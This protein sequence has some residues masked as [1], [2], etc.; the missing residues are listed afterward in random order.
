MADSEAV[1]IVGFSCRVAGADTPDGFWELLRTGADAVREFPA[2]RRAAIPPESPDAA[3]PHRPRRGGYLDEVDRFDPEFFGID[4]GEAALMDP[5]QRLMLELCWEALE[6]A[7]IP[8][9]G[10]SGG[11]VGVFAG[12]IWDDYAALLRRAGVAAGSRQVTGLHRSMIANRV[13][14]ALGLRTTGPGRSR[15]PRSPTN[16]SPPCTAGSP[17]AD[18]W[19]TRK[20]CWSARPGCAR[21]VRTGSA[22]PAWPAPSGC[23]G[24][25]RTLG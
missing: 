18:R 20:R 11:S 5:Q 22:W 23:R 8:A 17:C 9:H 10:L 21:P 3:A 12:A 25:V 13:S 15:A 16:C 1:A 19:T 14:Y 6:H 4:P 24:A 7:G 2:E